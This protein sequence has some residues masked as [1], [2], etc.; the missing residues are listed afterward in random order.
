MDELLDFAEITAVE[1]LED[2]LVQAGVDESFLHLLDDERSLRRR[3][4]ND[5]VAREESRDERVDEGQVGVL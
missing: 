4:D 5:A 2:V 1:D 3:F